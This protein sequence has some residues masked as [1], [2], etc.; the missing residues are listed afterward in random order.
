M[1]I[2]QSVGPN[3]KTTY[4]VL[5]VTPLTYLLTYMQSQPTH[6][7]TALTWWDREAIKTWE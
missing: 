4:I 7:P 3:M 2:P 1:T 5:F 6:G